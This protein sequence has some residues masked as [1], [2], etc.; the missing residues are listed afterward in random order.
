MSSDNSY[1]GC[2]F[3]KCG[4]SEAFL[5]KI[6][7]AAVHSKDWS[8]AG[9][10][11]LEVNRNGVVK[12]VNAVDMCAD[13]DCPDKK[14]CTVNAQA[15]GGNF[16]VDLDRRALLNLFGESDWENEYSKIQVRICNSFN[17]ND[18]WSQL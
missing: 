17:P 10:H 3:E 13:S 18:L 9:Y 6:P 7:S 8:I 15:F 11:V 12:K 5:N 14:C 2:F 16:L 4:I 1:I